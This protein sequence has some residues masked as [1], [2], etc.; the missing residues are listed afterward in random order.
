MINFQREGCDCS[1]DF[2]HCIR[3]SM[4]CG[5][6]VYKYKSKKQVG[7]QKIKL[8]DWVRPAS[9]MD[10][11][12]STWTWTVCSLQYFIRILL[13]WQLS[14]LWLI[15]PVCKVLYNFLS[16]AT[17]C[18]TLYRTTSRTEGKLHIYLILLSFSGLELWENAVIR[19]SAVVCML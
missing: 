13:P 15:S 2:F 11:I 4:K 14:K 8:V 16:A 3:D 9:R 12:I 6:V 1:I 17:C 10:I 19:F 18:H 7:F 5:I